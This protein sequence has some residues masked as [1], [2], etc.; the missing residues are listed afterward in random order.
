[1]ETP[2]RAKDFYENYAGYNKLLRSWLVAFGFGVPATLLLNEKV[3]TKLAY[4][5]QLKYVAILFIAGAAAQV[6]IAF[7]NKLA[8][9][10]SYYGE[11]NGQFKQSCW[12]R[13]GAWLSSMFWIDVILDIVSIGV[14]G[15][16]VW[17]VLTV[18]TQ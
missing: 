9:W 4:Q 17:T 1:M 13:L 14:F 15:V 2:D 5:C 3:A 12:Y 6:A 8:A 7:I 18:Y 16:G 10:L 11:E